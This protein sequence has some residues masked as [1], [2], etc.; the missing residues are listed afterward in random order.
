VC[1]EVIRVPLEQADL[2]IFDRVQAGDMIFV[3]SSHQTFTNSDVV[4]FMLDVLPEL[5][6]GVLI[7]VHDIL[8][9][10]DYLPMWQR[11]WFSEQYLVAAYLLAEGEWLRP[12]LA[13]N[14]ASSHPELQKVFAPLWADPRMEGVD[15]RG[16]VLW[17]SIAEGRAPSR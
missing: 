12:V 10:D 11:Y 9:P 3:D 8:L 14:Y 5:P 13:C 17:L 15:H 4:T 1:D 6:R 16:F 2:S 7:G